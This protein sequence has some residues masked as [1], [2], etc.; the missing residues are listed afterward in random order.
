MKGR[1][2][3]NI[4]EKNLLTNGIVLHDSCMRKSEVTQEGIEPG[5][6]WWEASRLTIQPPWSPRAVCALIV[7]TAAAHAGN[8]SERR[9]QISN[10][11]STC[12]PPTQPLG[13]SSSRTVANQIR[14]GRFPDPRATYQSM[15]KATSQEGKERPQSGLLEPQGKE[16]P[17]S[18]LVEPQGK[19]RPQSGL[20]E[21]QGKERS[22]SGLLEPQ[23]KERPQSGLLEPQGKER[24][25]SGLLEPQGKERS[26]SGLLEPQGKE[27]P[28]SGLLEPQ[29]K[30]R[31]Q[32]GLLEPQGK[33]RP[34][35]GLLEPQGKERPQSGLLEPQGKEI[36][37]SGL[38]EPQGKER[39][40][41]GLLEPQGKER[42]QSGLLEPQGKERPQ[43]GLLEPQGKERPQFGL[44]EPQGKERP[45][46]ASWNR[47]AKK[48]LSLA[49]SNRRAKKDL[50]L[51]SW[52]RRAKKDLSLA[53][54]NRRV[55]KDLS[56]ASWN[57]RAK[58]DLVWPLGTAGQRK[59]SSGLLEPQGKER[60][61]SG[62]LEP[63]GKERPQS[64]LL[65]PQGTLIPSEIVLGFSHLGI[66]PEDA[67]FLG[68][69]QF[70]LP[71]HSGTAPYS[72]HF[73]LIGPH[74]LV[75]ESHTN[76]S[77][78]LYQDVATTPQYVTQDHDRN[79][80][81]LTRRSD[82]A[83]GRVLVSPVSLPRL[84]TLNTQLHTPLN[85]EVLRA[86]GGEASDPSPIGRDN[87]ILNSVNCLLTNP[88]RSVPELRNPEWFHQMRT[89]H[90][91]PMEVWQELS[92]GKKER[93]KRKIPEK[94]RRP[95]ASS[96]TI[97]TYENPMTRPGI[98]ASSPWWEASE[99]PA[100]P[101][102]HQHI[103]E[104]NTSQGL[105][106][107]QETGGEEPL[108]AGDQ[109]HE[110]VLRVA[111][112]DVPGATKTTFTQRAYR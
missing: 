60:P 104:T 29:G 17:Q 83:L 48:D 51:A 36:P 9:S 10:W 57:R 50:S 85:S 7:R 21:P 78:P 70:P 55:K 20:L 16:R 92:A 95:T 86:D 4:P 47:R 71:L 73:T 42:P 43:S 19:E 81:H 12:Q 24:P 84:L 88:K 97:P 67:G 32:S 39:P 77:S 15:S 66:V 23:G 109:L 108:N 61:Q 102:R 110:Y 41:S 52:N 93:R 111:F 69:L 96:G 74:H 13:N 18:G 80:A 1:G 56:L 79:T 94:T 112:T 68:D 8:I 37:Q 22:Q 38:L 3:R 62:L 54:W 76:L 82:E 53:S 27:R 34:Q 28:Q 65:E 25:Q 11:R 106:T 14:S 107:P 49:S 72:P 44:L 26:Q 63:Q 30:E 91:Q 40:Q 103:F 75:V 98:E 45:R 46:L 89:Q 87:D 59:T 2:K 99:P 31:P 5:S 100:R 105:L 101:P 6:P 58:K 33:E 64:G 90:Q 35:S